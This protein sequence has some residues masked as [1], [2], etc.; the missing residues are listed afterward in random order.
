MTG[1]DIQHKMHNQTTWS[2]EPDSRAAGE[3]L[4]C[5][6]MSHTINILHNTV[7]NKNT[8]NGMKEQTDPLLVQDA[9]SCSKHLGAQ[10]QVLFAEGGLLGVLGI[11]L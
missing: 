6:T 11:V 9:I 2:H 5:E 4:A 1:Q 8:S 3:S 10:G 7:K